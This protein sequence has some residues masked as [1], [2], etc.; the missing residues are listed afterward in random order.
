MPVPVP[1]EDSEQQTVVEYLQMLNIPHWHTPNN[2]WTKSWSQK[3]KNKRLGVSAGIPDL[4][5]CVAGK[6]FGI[7][8]KRKKGGVV[9]ASQM[10]WIKT[11]NSHG[12]ET[13]VSNGSGPAIKFINEKRKNTTR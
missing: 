2:T 9:S 13:I 12:I 4:F 7:E 6:V 3:M 5:F 8:M 10:R 1:S 11:L